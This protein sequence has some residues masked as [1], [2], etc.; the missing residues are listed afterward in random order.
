M[1]RPTLPLGSLRLLTVACFVSAC[2]A[3]TTLLPDNADEIDGAV[4]DGSGESTAPPGVCPPCPSNPT[5]S[6]Q[7]WACIESD[8]CTFGWCDANGFESDKELCGRAYRSAAWCVGQSPGAGGSAS[9]QIIAC[10]V[11]HDPEGPLCT[12]SPDGGATCSRDSDGGGPNCGRIACGTG[13]SCVCENFCWCG[14]DP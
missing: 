14:E 3:R 6:A 1:R 13:C 11:A 4:P 7:P 2:G 5:C 12:F 9:V 10:S 8:G